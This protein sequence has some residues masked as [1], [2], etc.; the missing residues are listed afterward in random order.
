M[1]DKWKDLIPFYVAG[2][3]TDK[4][5]QAVERYLNDCG[6]P[7]FE[8][9]E[10]WRQVASATWQYGNAVAQDLPPLSQ[11]VRAE[12]ARDNG[13]GNI[14]TPGGF[15]EESIANPT[16]APVY[17]RS[18]SQPKQV[19]RAPRVP[20]TMVAAFVTVVLFGGILISQLKPGDLDPGAGVI[21]L[22]EAGDGIVTQQ[23]GGSVGLD[24][25]S[26]TPGNGGIIATPTQNAPRPSA[27]FAP[28][29]TPLP[30]QQ[31]QTSE[32][33]IAGAT[34]TPEG[35]F[36]RNDTQSAISIYQNASFD[37]QRRT[38]TSFVPGSI[39][40]IR[41]TFNGWYE[42]S[43]GNWVYGGNLSIVGD[44]SNLLTATPTLVGWDN[45]AT[46][47]PGVPQCVLSNENSDPVMLYQWPDTSSAPN[48]RLSPGEQVQIYIGNQQG[49]YQVFYAQWAQAS[50][51]SVTGTGCN[52]L[53]VPTPTIQPVATLPPANP[54]SADHPVAVVTTEYT[55]LRGNPSTLGIF[56]EQVP[57][58]TS[59][60]IIAHN[61]QNGPARWYLVQSPNGRT[62]WVPSLDVNAQPNDLSV[63]VA[64]TVPVIPT[65]TPT[66]NLSTPTIEQWAHITTVQEHGCGGTVGAQATIPLQIQ[67]SS[68]GN[69]I[70]LTYTDTLVTFNLSRMAANNYAG[71]YGTGA[72]INVSLTFTSA[73]TYTA[74]EVITHESGC[75]VRTSWDGARG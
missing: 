50:D 43:Y 9:L 67:R 74:Q 40:S 73:T 55:L 68:D 24:P 6:A 56:I 17:P 26:P 60:S 66:N 33:A 28:T 20:L 34:V 27:T 31:P 21:Q 35:C 45:T 1:Q 47:D 48:G 52:N 44:C 7:C 30:S 70:K 64:V 69:S 14:I 42:L 58:N 8:E 36:V 75:V 4:E 5:R 37:A 15:R 49:W 2:T 71:S 13:Q 10:T 54:P 53:W 16:G 18:V 25:A 32:L 23:F 51:V 62:G 61:G 38:N 63:N 65:V 57:Q 39:A 72:T 41:V 11:A 12:V 19:R 59:L 3:L 29:T 22:T 46:P